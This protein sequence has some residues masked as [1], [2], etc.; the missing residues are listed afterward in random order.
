MASLT[1]LATTV[2]NKNSPIKVRTS[3]DNKINIKIYE[4]S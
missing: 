3:N 4:K 1:G 2:A